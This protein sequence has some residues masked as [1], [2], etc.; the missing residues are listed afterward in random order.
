MCRIEADN[1][2]TGNQFGS[3]LCFCVF[4][5]PSLPSESLVLLGKRSL[6]WGRGYLL[7]PYYVLM[8]VFS[9]HHYF[10]R[11]ILSCPF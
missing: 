10:I 5:I 4:T 11:V 2:Y 9:S 6:C 3:A 8:A 7:S 1:Q